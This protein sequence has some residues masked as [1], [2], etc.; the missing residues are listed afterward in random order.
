MLLNLL[1]DFRIIKDSFIPTYIICIM[2]NKGK[3]KSP[4]TRLQSWIVFEVFFT[5]RQ[6]NK[7]KKKTQQ[8]GI[9]D[10]I[11]ATTSA[12]KVSIFC[13]N[14]YLATNNFVAHLFLFL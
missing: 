5:L 9:L 12:K 1:D 13:F 14:K 2:L 4:I 10:E 11:P 7:A 3:T 6:K 8:T